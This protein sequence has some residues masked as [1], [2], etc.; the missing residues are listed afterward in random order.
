MDAS[1][2][3]PQDVFRSALPVGTSLVVLF[4][5]SKDRD[6]QPI[7]QDYWVDEVLRALGRLFRGATAYLRGKG[8]WRDDQRGG[9]LLPEEPVIV[10]SY[11]AGPDL[12]VEALTD[13]YR[14]L[15]RMGREAKQG[16]IGVVID[17]K[18]YGITDYGEG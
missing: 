10:F 2:V 11:V 18:Y 13:L 3:N 15:S 16:E 1:A 5:P 12:T 8:V 4:V 9:T 6:G 14:T 17:G 7:E